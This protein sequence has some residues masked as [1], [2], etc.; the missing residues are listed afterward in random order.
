MDDKFD[1]LVD[2]FSTLLAGRPDSVTSVLLATV[3]IC[4]GGY[5]ADQDE[6]LFK[7]Y[8]EFG[9]EKVLLALVL[10]IERNK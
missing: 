8:S 7:F 10:A 2:Y 3:R 5:R 1:Y 4:Q 9:W 6:F